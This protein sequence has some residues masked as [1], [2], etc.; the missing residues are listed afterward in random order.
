MPKAKRSASP[1]SEEALSSKRQRVC[2]NTETNPCFVPLSDEEEAFADLD[3]EYPFGLHLWART[4]N[5]PLKNL[6]DQVDDM[7]VEGLCKRLE[8][9]AHGCLLEGVTR[10]EILDAI[11]A[12]RETVVVQSETPYNLFRGVVQRCARRAFQRELGEIS[13]FDR[14]YRSVAADE[15]FR[16]ENDRDVLKVWMGERSPEFL[17]MDPFPPGSGILPMECGSP[18]LF[19]AE[20]MLSHGNYVETGLRLWYTVLWHSVAHQQ[21]ALNLSTL[22]FAYL[23]FWD[24][25][26]Q[27]K[28][29]NSNAFV[30]YCVEGLRLLSVLSVGGTDLRDRLW[31][32]AR[33][34][35]DR[36]RDC[37]RAKRP[38]RFYAMAD[39][40]GRA[41]E[42]MQIH[43]PEEDGDEEL[44]EIIASASA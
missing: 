36:A 7:D 41:V 5:R 18:V 20:M 38:R 14:F 6:G 42:P 19:A 2:M 10:P 35:A 1:S 22:L 17:G 30:G 26:Y 25:V 28:G 13:R 31:V 43:S 21:I 12:F 23:V 11:V 39:W 15:V 4:V 16:L 27:R 3:N 29:G 9:V 44:N 8:Q 33:T 24:A 37:G 32:S 34:F 40:L